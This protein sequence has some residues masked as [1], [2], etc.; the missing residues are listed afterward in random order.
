MLSSF[1]GSFKKFLFIQINP[2][3]IKKKTVIPGR[4][5]QDLQLDSEQ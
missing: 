2:I 1:T 3:K 5:G 4:P